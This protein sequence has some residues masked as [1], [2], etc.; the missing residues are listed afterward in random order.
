VGQG[1]V[2]GLCDFGYFKGGIEGPQDYGNEA[3]GGDG[4]W[5]V[6]S[7]PDGGKAGGASGTDREGRGRE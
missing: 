3:H 6:E 2:A 5:K 4:G 1:E 7:C